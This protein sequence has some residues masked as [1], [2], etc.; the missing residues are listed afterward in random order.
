MN[1]TLTLLGV[2]L[3]VSNTCLLAQNMGPHGFMANEGQVVDQENRT[4]T[5]VKYLLSAQNGLN[6]QVRAKGFS[7]DTYQVQQATAKNQVWEA[8]TPPVAHQFHRVDI[9]FLGANPDS[10]LEV[11]ET[12]PDHLVFYPQTHPNGLIVRHS[13]RLVFKELYP[14]TDLELLANGQSGK[15][16]E[17]NFLLHPGA[18]LSDIRMVYRGALNMQLKDEELDLHLVH[19]HLK[20]TIPASYWASTQKPVQIRYQMIQAFAQENGK[21]STCVVGFAGLE[22][23]VQADLVIDPIPNLDWATYYGGSGTDQGRDLARDGIGNVYITG[24]SVSPNNIATA[25]VHQNTWAG[26]NDALLAK[27]NANGQRLWGAYYGGTGSDSGQGLAVSSQGD[28][29]LVGGSNSGTGIASAGIHQSTLQGDVDVYIA[30]FNPN[31]I[32]TWGT[33]FG[34]A[35]YDFGNAIG[36]DAVGNLYITGWT[37]STAGIATNG[38]FKTTYGGQFDGFVAKFTENGQQ[39]WGTY[40]GDAEFE[41]GLALVSE[42]NGGVYVGGWSSSTQGIASAGAFQ[43]TYAGGTADMFLMQ[44]NANGQRIWGT[45]YGG[46][47]DEYADGIAKDANNNIYITGQSS[48]PNN[49]SSA[50]AFQTALKG[51]IDLVLAKFSPSGQ[52]IW[53]TYFGDAG[54]DIGYGIVL[55]PNNSGDIYVSGFSNSTTGIA[56]TNAY[57]ETYAGGL[58][59]A[60]LAKFNNNG[61]LRWATYYGG[62][63]EDRAYGLEMDARLNLFTVGFTE[64]SSMGIASSNAHQRNSGGGMDLLLARFADCYAPPPPTD[65]NNSANLEVCAGN[66]LTLRVRGEGSITW[67]SAATGGRL[68]GRGDS[69]ITGPLLANTTFFAQDS[70]CAP[71]ETRTPIQVIVNAQ[72]QVSGGGNR[73]VCEGESLSLS[74]SGASTYQWDQGLVNGQVFQVQNSRTYQVIGTDTKGCKDTAQVQITANARPQVSG[75]ADRSLCEGESTTLSG[76]GAVTYQWDRNVT[77]GQAFQPSATQTYTLIGS[78]ANN[79]KDTAQIVITVAPR[80]QLNVGSDRRVCEGE[81]VTLTATG[82]ANYTWNQGIV[83][84]QAFVPPSTTTYQVIGTSGNCRDSARV[85]ITVVGRPQVEAGEDRRVCAGESLSLNAT[86]ANTY[87]WSPSIVPGQAFRPNATRTYTVIGIDANNCR[88]TDQVVVNV[89][90]LPLLDLGAN[91]S[92]CEGKPAVIKAVA[93][94]GTVP[95]SF[96]WSSGEV[97]HQITPKPKTSSSYSVTVSDGQ[98]CK[99]SGQISV[100]VDARPNAEI[101]SER[102][103]ACEGESMQLRGEGSGGTGPYTYLWSVGGVSSTLNVMPQNSANYALTISDAKGC[104]DTAIINL[105]VRKKPN[106]S[107]GP[108]ANLTLCNADTLQLSASGGSV[109]AWTGPGGFSSSQAQPRLWPVQAGIYEVKVTNAEQCSA[110]GN[111]QVNL[112]ANPQ[113]RISGPAQICAGE[114]LTLR[115]SGGGTYQWS[116]GNTAAQII[117]NPKRDSSYKVVV[118]SDN[119]CRDTARI[120]VKVLPLPLI[121]LAKSTN[122]RLGGSVTLNANGDAQSFQWSP[123]GGLSC[124]NC[125]DPVLKGILNDATYC[126]TATTENCSSRACI[127]VKVAVECAVYAPTAF[128]P[129]QDQINDTFCPQSPCLK[130]G[131]LWVF[132]RWGG[133]VFQGRGLDTCWDGSRKGEPAPIGTYLFQFVGLDINDKKVVLGGEVQLLR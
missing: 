53:G 62:A 14:H 78:D 130:D 35:Q 27:F 29:Y 51:G 102:P 90:P 38:A 30:K 31:G 117:L 98:N 57:Q 84:G 92:I 120:S 100:Q 39:L 33:Y 97:S 123:G 12:A 91:Q 107:V 54:N 70:V 21:A 13:K 56:T 110:L 126:V 19:G 17:Y 4:N 11:A 85:V 104:Q 43:G 1:K 49:I 8:N 108:A 32:R 96:S 40:F 64:G 9:D 55:A 118:T 125:P 66:G 89:F 94:G 119:K 5:S 121:E 131:E 3:C 133:L 106:I 132:D 22:S 47:G 28:V 77:N 6:V 2:L 44:F 37:R 71:S 105:P 112:A 59:D 74:G 101:K 52:R 48:S 7:Y 114:R 25:G 20:E 103:F 42:N 10:W 36:L 75:G 69:L 73:S 68:L 18:N 60:I 65:L 129:N 41:L 95:Y 87:F 16:F 116:T 80:P 128:S 82:A 34:G 67:H 76:S 115:A 93:S 86:G 45:Y 83:N 63:G 58:N 109:Y 111:V 127:E 72:P 46:S 88:D 23:A 81:S 113:A 61:A 50:G 26:D 24:L 122:L 99:A 79:C 124:N 15:P